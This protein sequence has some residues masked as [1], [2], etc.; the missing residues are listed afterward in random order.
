MF[1]ALQLLDDFVQRET[2]TSNAVKTPT[3]MVYLSFLIAAAG[4]KAETAFSSDQN[5]TETLL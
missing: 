3:L 1:R 5:I 4:R 2:A